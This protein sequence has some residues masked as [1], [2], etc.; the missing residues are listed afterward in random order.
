LPDLDSFITNKSY[1]LPEI[2]N[3]FSSNT[4]VTVYNIDTFLHQYVNVNTA[5]LLAGAYIISLLFLLA[6][7]GTR[8][9][10][11]VAAFLHVTFVASMDF[12]VYGVDC[13]T[14]IA[15]FYCIVFP[16]GRFGSLDNYVRMKRG[17]PEH[18]TNT[19]YINIC[20][21]VL[22]LH[23]CIAY[24]FSGFDKVIG[25][26]W[27]NGESLWKAMHLCYNP[28]LVSLD[29]L[30]DTP[31]FFI[32]GWL[33]VIM[34]ICY[35]VF[36]NIRKTRTL[37]LVMIIGLHLSIAVLM[38]LFFFATFMIILSVTAFYMPY[39][40]LKPAGETQT[41]KRKKLSYANPI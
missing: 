27:W 37:W 33:T 39:M 18:V 20:L 8:V 23:M 30:A 41:L 9:A 19:P 24:F 16:V 35:P 22:Q 2:V 32:F 7:F 3:A 1:I 10:A 25:Y 31:F 26:N 28:Y 13:F 17:K 5:T 21:R 15:L 4:V 11:V 36:M 34:E 12:F 29:F 40:A 38:G 6:G 14:T